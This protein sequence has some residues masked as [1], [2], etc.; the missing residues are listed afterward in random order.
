METTSKQSFKFNIKQTDIV[1]MTYYFEHLMIL[2]QHQA[3]IVYLSCES[4]VYI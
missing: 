2:F 1:T 4:H 3:R